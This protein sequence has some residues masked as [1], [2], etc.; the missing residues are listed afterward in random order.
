MQGDETVRT[1]RRGELLS[2]IPLFESL[3]SEDLRSLA[4]RLENVEHAEGEVIFQQGAEGSSLF[5]IEEGAVEISYGDGKGRV[6]LAHLF[7][8][9][10]FGELSVFDGAPRSATATATRRSRLVRL[11]RD[12]LVDF[13]NKNP[14]AA[15]RIIAEMSER[16]RQ[17]NELMSRQVS[18]NVLE[19]EA[20]R[21]TIGQR[22]ADRVA[23]FGGSW[24]FIFLFG[25]VMVAWMGINIF[26]LTH[27]D[28]YPF[29]LLNLGLSALAALQAPI[30]MMSQNRQSAKDK[31]LAENDY[32][33]NLKA[34]MEIGAMMRAQAE[35]MAR[36][37]LVERM[38][39]RRAGEAPPGA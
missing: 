8:G 35:M 7:P 39:A 3:T 23:A 19:E 9:Q 10:Y 32:Q 16:L 36:L 27:Y 38:L 20:E 28:P 6:L 21:L 4:K 15:L 31:L 25:G 22:V 13:V 5:I 29:I 11:D 2:N 33:V 24:P 37:A 34:E 1:R 12:D 14:A 30:I 26:A 18:R 17:T